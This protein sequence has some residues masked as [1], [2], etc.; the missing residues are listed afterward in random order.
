MCTLSLFMPV[1]LI[2]IFS[3][4]AFHMSLQSTARVAVLRMNR[5]TPILA[6]LATP[7][8]CVGLLPARGGIYTQTHVHHQQ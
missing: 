5:T 3:H 2:Q 1:L 6:C 7:H 8:M 4:L